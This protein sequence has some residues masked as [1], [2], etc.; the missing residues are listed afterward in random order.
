MLFTTDIT[1][2]IGIFYVR[3]FVHLFSY[4]QTLLCFEI[5]KRLVFTN[6]GLLSAGYCAK[7][8]QRDG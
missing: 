1:V 8:M 7:D 6:L 5:V 3:C 4:V 2:K